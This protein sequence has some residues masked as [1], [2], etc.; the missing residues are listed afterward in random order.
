MHV[1]VTILGVGLGLLA[2]PYAYYLL[3]VLFMITKCPHCGRIMQKVVY[4]YDIGTVKRRIVYECRFCE[5]K[6]LKPSQRGKKVT[7][8][9]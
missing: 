9:P 5:S 6:Y 3:R 4:T 8:Y 7:L 2:V 1:I